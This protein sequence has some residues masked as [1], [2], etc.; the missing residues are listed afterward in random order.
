MQLPATAT[1][2]EACS[3]LQALGEDTDRIDASALAVFD[4]SV[5]ALI[6]EARRRAQQRGKA[7]VV[8]GAPP[9]LLQLASLYGVEEL[10]S[11]DTAP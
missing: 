9:R 2:V 1:L 4:T 11:F 6:L 5:L 3:L 8:H 7:L 10:L